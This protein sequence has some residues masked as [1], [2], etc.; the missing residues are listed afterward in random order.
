[1]G[2]YGPPGPVGEA[3]E[4]RAEL[5]AITGKAE[6]ALN[7]A[8]KVIE[9]TPRSSEPFVY[10]CWLKAIMGKDLKGAM[11][12][13]DEAIRRWS[14]VSDA[15]E[16]LLAR[17]LI[18]FKSGDMSVAALDYS[19]LTARTPSLQATTCLTQILKPSS[20]Y[21]QGVIRSR[22][23]DTDGA[24]HEIES[25]KIFDP[26]IADRYASYGVPPPETGSAAR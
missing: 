21:M 16:F 15:P 25:A 26:L 20:L 9:L 11:A 12:D 5:Y 22:T 10:R 2:D 19:T 3:Y 18:E 7:D 13:C 17:A 14:T 23:G 6:S 8:A 4:R 24:E 1:M